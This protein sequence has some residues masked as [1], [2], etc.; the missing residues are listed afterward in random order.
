MGGKKLLSQKT[1]P[2]KQKEITD[3]DREHLKEVFKEDVAALQEAFGLHL[4]WQE[5]N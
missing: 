2:V 5:F 4:N 1:Q 3:T